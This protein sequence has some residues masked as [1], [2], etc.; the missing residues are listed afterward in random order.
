MDR[1]M[2]LVLY[3]RKY[4]EIAKKMCGAA[5]EKLTNAGI[6]KI[7]ALLGLYKSSYFLYVNNEDGVLGGGGYIRKY[8]PKSKTKETWIAGIYVLEKFR[9]QTYGTKLMLA[10]LEKCAQKGYEKVYLYV[11]NCNYSARRL[12]DKLGF[13]IVGT[14]KHYY[15]MQYSLK[16]K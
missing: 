15:K 8:N 1:I 2:Q 7:F 12:Y 9:C 13:V 6:Y 14:Y 5:F 16:N 11:D 10:L 3:S 4:N